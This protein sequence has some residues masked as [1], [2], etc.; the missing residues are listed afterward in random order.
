MAQYNWA[1]PTLQTNV[2]GNSLIANTAV[3]IGNV[4]NGNINNFIP[5]FNTN[6]SNNIAYGNITSLVANASLQF[7][8]ANLTVGAVQVRSGGNIDTPGDVNSSTLYAGSGTVFNSNTINADFVVNGYNAGSIGPITTAP[9]VVID[10]INGSW[11]I[12]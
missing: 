12:S 7:D 1:Q 6:N 10:I 3:G 9:G 4:G 8:G 2:I 5:F 11:V